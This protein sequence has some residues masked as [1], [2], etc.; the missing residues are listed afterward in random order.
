MKK[1][2]ILAIV[3]TGIAAAVVLGLLRLLAPQ[4]L[5]AP[6]DMEMVQASEEVPPFFDGVFRE[7]DQAAEGFLIPDPFLH[8]RP[9]PLLFD[10]AKGPTDLLGFRNRAVPSVADVVVIG[11]SQTWGNNAT[12]EL[13]WP[14]QLGEALG[15]KRPVVYGM[16]V[17]GWGAVEYLEIFPKALRLRP[18]VI[19][20]ALYAGNDPLDSFTRAFRPHGRD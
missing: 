13:N 12:L 17:G 19:V 9:K 14:S 20:V 6:I 10:D 3:S 5:G 11:D 2:W 18:R 15:V 8:R 4:L 16:A 7:A 1:E